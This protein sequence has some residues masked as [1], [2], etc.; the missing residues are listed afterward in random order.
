ME[1]DIASFGFDGSGAGHANGA[2]GPGGATRD[3][4]KRGGSAHDAGGGQSWEPCGQRPASWHQQLFHWQRP[5]KVAHRDSAVCPES[6]IRA[7]IRASTWFFY[8]SQGHLEYDFKVA[9]GA[10][11]SQAE[12]QFDGGAKLELRHGD[13]ILKGTGADVRLQAPRVIRALP[14]ISSRLKAGSCSGRPIAW[15]SRWIL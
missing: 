8:G 10:D 1:P 13:L 6:V 3:G 12:L 5:E 14:A 7:F 9:P 2:A 4:A 15:A 11:P